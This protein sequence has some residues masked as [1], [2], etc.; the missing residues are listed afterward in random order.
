MWCDSWLHNYL[1]CLFPPPNLTESN[2]EMRKS[3]NTV[4]QSQAECE[5]FKGK[6]EKKTECL[7]CSYSLIGSICLEQAYRL[8]PWRPRTQMNISYANS[9]GPQLQPVSLYQEHLETHRDHEEKQPVSRELISAI[10]SCMRCSETWLFWEVK[11]TS[12][13]HSWRYDT[14][15]F[16]SW[17]IKS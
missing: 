12:E 10:P 13:M 6:K 15:F 14:F 2:T 8:L 4:K 7:F 11:I 9:E 5:N 3:N 16:L 17:T 1:I